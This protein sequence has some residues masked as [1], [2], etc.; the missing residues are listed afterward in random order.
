MLGLVFPTARRYICNV[1]VPPQHGLLTKWMAMVAGAEQRFT[2]TAYIYK[3]SDYFVKE[4]KE[5]NTTVISFLNL[6]VWRAAAAAMNYVQVM[7]LQ[8]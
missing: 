7:R 3:P 8:Q 5:T 4:T 6:L 2:L 1:G